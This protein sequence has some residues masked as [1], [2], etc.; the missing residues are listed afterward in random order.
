[1]L[2][3]NL[4]DFA[5]MEAGFWTLKKQ[6]VSVTKLINDTVSDIQSIADNK[7]IEIN[8]FASLSKQLVT[9]VDITINCDFEQIQRVLI[10]LIT[11]SIKYTQESGKIFVWYETI[12][13]DTIQF[14]VEDSGKGIAKENLDKVFNRFYR[15]DHNLT[16]KESGFGIGLSICKKIV[17]LHNGKIWAKSDGLEKGSRFSFDIKL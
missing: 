17:E 3:N 7:K 13:P 4:L 15:V 6:D 11:N 16:K 5:K 10:N 9:P 8:R 14:T 12:S 2:V 1:M